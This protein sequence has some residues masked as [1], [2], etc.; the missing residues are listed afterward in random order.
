[1]D[2]LLSKITFM[3][4]ISLFWPTTF[5]FNNYLQP[6]KNNEKFNLFTE[7]CNITEK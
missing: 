4:D 6:L 7:I 3:F 2:Y 5:K 1:M